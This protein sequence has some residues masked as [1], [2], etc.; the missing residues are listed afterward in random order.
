MTVDRI[1]A[2]ARGSAAVIQS[3]A[4]KR[5]FEGRFS[6]TMADA[7]IKAGVDAPERLLFMTAA[8]IA[9]L[10]GIGAGAQQEIAIYQARFRRARDPQS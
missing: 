3:M 1:R 8:E 5:L 9:A 6:P 2:L 10:P 7:L 4:A